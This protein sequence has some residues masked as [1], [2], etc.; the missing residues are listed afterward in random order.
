M[1][2]EIFSTV[3]AGNL[4]R[5]R[6][7]IKKA[8]ASFEGKPVTITIERTK[9]KRT[10]RQ[11]RFYCG[12]VVPLIR[13]GLNDLGHFYTNQQAHELVKQHIADNYPDVIIEEVIL[14]GLA[15]RRIRSTSEF[16]TSE[17]MDYSEVVAQF[18]ADYLSIEIP[19][20]NEQMTIE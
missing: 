13:Q 12:V 7:L 2:V 19:E 5:N 15:T 14:N 8:I 16:S 18:A 3:E 4:K 10:N 1:K 17:F 20:P 11:N 6:P 9:K